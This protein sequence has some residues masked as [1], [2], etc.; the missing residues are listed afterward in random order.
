M[1]FTTLFIYVMSFYGLFASTIMLI[2]FFEDTNKLKNP[3]LTRFPKVTVIVPAYNEGNNVKK[4][5]NSLLALDYPKDKLEI[6][7]V[8][9]GSTDN[10]LGILR[11]YETKGVIVYTKPN[12][13]KGNSLNF[14]LERCTGEIVGALDADSFVPKNALKKMLGYFDDKNVMAVA[15]SVKIWAPKTW[16]GRIQLIEFLMV[17]PVRKV[18]SYLGG[19]PIAP[20]PLTLYRK[21]FF[22]KYGGYD[23]KN[24]SEDIEIAMRIESRKYL[25]ENA[26]DVNVY[27][28]A[29]PKL[30]EMYVQRLRWFRGFI[31]NMVKYKHMFFKK[32]YGNMGMFVMP[33]SVLSVV[34][35]V[36]GFSFAVYKLGESFYNSFL[37]MFLI[38]F[39]FMPLVKLKFDPF[40]INTTST[41]VL[42]ILLIITGIFLLYV[43]KKYSYEKQKVSYGYLLFFLLY[44]F[45]SSFTWINA[46][47]YKLRNKKIVWGKKEL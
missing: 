9:D 30:K 4:T 23:A 31:D 5:L 40:F 39:D 43:A 20:G 10:T 45:I 22:D 1:D 7:A 29:K 16:P 21:W 44:W 24:I 46:V 26:I 47:I 13:G 42:P 41:M 32:E 2:T 8:D 28:M 3:K 35:S 6:I 12:S 27:T 36:I 11:K 18:F 38:N 34:M 14:A 25:I 33:I 37:K 19:V 15:P 17:A